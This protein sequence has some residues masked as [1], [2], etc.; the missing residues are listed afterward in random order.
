L[1][2]SAREKK[3]KSIVLNEVDE[4]NRSPINWWF[5][6]PSEKFAEVN[7]NIATTT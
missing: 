4:G 3:Q 5:E 1:Q 6:N 2:Q 7:K